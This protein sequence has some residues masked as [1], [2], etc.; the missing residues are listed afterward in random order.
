VPSHEQ[1]A[2]ISS[3][4]HAPD[5][6][7]GYADTSCRARGYSGTTRP[8]TF[9]R[10]IADMLAGRVAGQI[11]GHVADHNAGLVSCPAVGQVTGQVTCQINGQITR[12]VAGQITGQITGRVVGQIVG[13][14]ADQVGGQILGQIAGQILGKIAAGSSGRSRR[15]RRVGPGAAALPAQTTPAANRRRHGDARNHSRK[16]NT[17]TVAFRRPPLR[18]GPE[19]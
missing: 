1:P 7:A 9:T 6:P 16:A 17:A 4:P 8:A 11:A 13:Q 19:T 18:H 3:H 2:G 15:P 10:Q 12:Q 5:A 14:I